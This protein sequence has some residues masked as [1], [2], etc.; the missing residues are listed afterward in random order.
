MLAHLSSYPD[1]PLRQRLPALRAALRAQP[2]L[3]E[4]RLLALEQLIDRL[5][6]AQ[7]LNAEATYVELFDRGRG[8]AL[9]LFEHVHGDS[10]DRGP[11]LIDLIQTYEAAGLY[12]TSD[13]LPDHLS[14]L[15]E[16]AST[17]PAAAAAAL[18]GDVTQI[19]RTLFSALT[20]RDSAYAAIPAALLELAGEPVQTGPVPPEPDLDQAWHE[21]EAFGG[22]STHGQRGPDQPQPIRIV[23]QA[24]T[25][26]RHLAEPGE[27]A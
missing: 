6:A 14:V 15:L 16:Y 26:P 21:P 10:R 19:L 3:G 23:R 12:L 22:C 17:Q 2:V 20:K 11:A 18:L 25:P 5:A 13:E 1:E 27:S 7:G 4:Q 24:A 8:T 9:L